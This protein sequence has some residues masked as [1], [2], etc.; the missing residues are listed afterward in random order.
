MKKVSLLKS[1][2]EVILPLVLL[3]GSRYFGVFLYALITPFQFTFS[4]TFDLAS[5]PFIRCGG[6]SNL[7]AANSFSWG[8]TAAVLGLTFGFIAFRNLY[9]H[10]DWLHP[11]Q[12]THLHKNR[13]DHLI[14]GSKEAFHQ[15]IS[16]GLVVAIAMLLSF[17]DLVTGFLS[18]LVFGTIVSVSASVLALLLLG[19]SRD[20]KLEGKKVE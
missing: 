12:A 20:S 3:L 17:A 14:V 19:I 13:M 2:D 1:I 6:S 7:I 9:L 16:W 15:G 8:L 5:L 11:K 4:S 18:T 10:E